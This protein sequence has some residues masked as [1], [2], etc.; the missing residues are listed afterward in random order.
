MRLRNSV[1]SL[2]KSIST[3]VSGTDTTLGTVS[4]D[5]NDNTLMG[6]MYVQLKHIHPT[7]YTYPDLGDGVSVTGG[8]DAW[9]LGTI[10]E[11]IP[12][13]T[14]TLPF[15]IHY[16]NIEAVNKTDIYKIVLYQ[17]AEGAETYLGSGRVAKDAVV[18]R[19]IAKPT[20]TVLIPANTRISAA[21]AS[22]SGG[23]DEMTISLEY[24]TY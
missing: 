5:E 16:I 24:H 15:D 12:A 8:D 4:N 2:L 11:I 17:G 1:I 20:G 22:S 3:I 14:V 9:T 7:I 19:T 23:E 13:N 21:L 10:V 6:R 18:S